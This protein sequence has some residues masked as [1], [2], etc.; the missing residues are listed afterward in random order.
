VQLR[1]SDGDHGSSRLFARIGVRGL[2]GLA[3]L[4]LA[5][6][7]WQLLSGR[8]SSPSPPNV[9]LI[10]VDT[11]RADHLG[12]YGYHRNTSPNLDSIAQRGI[13]VDAAQSVAPWTNPAIVS[14][15]TGLYPEA[16]LPTMRH[17]EAIRQAIPASLDTLAQRLKG[18]GYRTVALVDHPGIAPDLNF[19]AGF[20]V[21]ERLYLDSEVG[22]W[23]LSEADYVLERVQEHLQASSEAPL[24]LYLHVVY[25]HR[26]YEPPPSHQSLFGPGFESTRYLEREGMINMYDAE[27]RYTD[28]LIGR[29]DDSLLD[30]GLDDTTWM[31]VTSDHGEAFWEHD[32]AEHGNTLF[33]ELLH[34]PMILLPPGGR[35]TEPA[36]IQTRVSLV[37]VLPTV[38]DIAGVEISGVLDGQSLLGL[39]RG[40]NPGPKRPIF[41]ES[42]HSGDL[43]RAAVY[44]GP[45]KYLSGARGEVLYDLESDPLETRPLTEKSPIIEAMRE[46]L[47]RHRSRNE[48]RRQGAEREAAPLPETDLDEGTVK[49]LRALGYVDS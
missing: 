34:I 9:L 13:V 47:D 17:R 5:F 18:A 28:D 33:E 41:G 45:Y 21:F 19:G 12:A 14:L 40:E 38:L 43:S 2:A 44:R 49:R 4:A 35:S 29:I 23:Q 48:K 11:L 36:R 26:P 15:F 25:P 7:L 1:N 37:D 16:V 8:P 30:S 22:A 27:I 10:L 31:L 39:I 20:E 46:L 42:P 6:A 3:A 24:F 32:K